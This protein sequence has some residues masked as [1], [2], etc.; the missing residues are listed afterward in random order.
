MP[1][2]GARARQSDELRAESHA[3]PSQ[4]EKRNKVA[5]R[6][7]EIPGTTAL[8]GPAFR[9][10]REITFDKARPVPL[11]ERDDH[12]SRD[13]P[14]AI[15]HRL[16]TDEKSP[17]WSSPYLSFRRSNRELCRPRGEKTRRRA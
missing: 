13:V 14:G 6:G 9:L 11:I 2:D 8:A 17:R 4:Q 7:R 16:R 12:R 10:R 1:L 15:F 3:Y 5:Y